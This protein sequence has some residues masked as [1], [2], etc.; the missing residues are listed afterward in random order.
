ML[1]IV[2]GRDADTPCPY[3]ERGCLTKCEVGQSFFYEKEHTKNTR[4]HKGIGR[5][6]YNVGDENISTATRL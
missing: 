5:L 4:N 3:N 2:F 1:R 6:Q